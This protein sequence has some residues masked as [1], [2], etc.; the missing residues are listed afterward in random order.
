MALNSYAVTLVALNCFVADM[1]E[2]VLAD[3]HWRVRYSLVRRVRKIKNH[4]ISPCATQT[5]VSAHFH[6]WRAWVYLVEYTVH[7]TH[8]MRIRNL[9]ILALSSIALKIE[10]C[11]F[12]DVLNLN[13]C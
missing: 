9:S 3:K 4:I 7:N 1:L 6:L 8:T 11:K 12:S 10:N 2:L 13:N 5:F